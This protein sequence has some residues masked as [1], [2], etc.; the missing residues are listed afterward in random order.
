LCA[1]QDGVFGE[2]ARGG[3]TANDFRLFPTGQ[4]YSANGYDDDN[5]ASFHIQRLGKARP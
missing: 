5:L 3:N 2:S 1:G 4:G